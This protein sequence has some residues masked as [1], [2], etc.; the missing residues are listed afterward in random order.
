MTTKKGL[1]DGLD[2][3]LSTIGV[4]MPSSL[5]R[6]AKTAKEETDDASTADTES[7]YRDGT[8]EVEELA[9]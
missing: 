8:F 7:A 5:T 3:L 4:H 1:Y 6:E 2:W 9:A